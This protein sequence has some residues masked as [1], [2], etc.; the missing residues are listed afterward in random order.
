MKA[1]IGKNKVTSYIANRMY[2]LFEHD[3]TSL[4]VRIGQQTVLASKLLR[5]TYTK[6]SDAEVTVF[7]QWGEDGILD[8]LCDIAALE[9]PNILELGAGNF[10]ECNSRFLIENRLANSVLV[11]AR[12]DLLGTVERSGA[13]WKTHMLAI[14]SWITSKT[15]KEIERTSRDFLGCIDILSIDIDG[16]DYWVLAECDL[17]KVAIVVAEYNPIFGAKFPVTI[18]QQDNFVRSNAHYSNL[19]YGVGLKAWVDF[20]GKHG[21][22]LAG[23][24]KVGSNAFFIRE[25]L[26]QKLHFVPSTD[27]N[28]FINWG[29]RES[30]QK[31][32]RL[33]FLSGDDRRREIGHLEV[34]HIGSGKTLRVDSLT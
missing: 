1:T 30:R 34:T 12:P 11:D 13:Y 24:N 28:T 33:N 18:P 23:T 26:V 20:L 27:L 2:K 19:Y 17:S 6:L 14:N 32:G 21:F 22:A 25:N 16:N 7:S 29:V 15:I 3:L 4:R 31:N 5:N 10:E 9:R 8:Y